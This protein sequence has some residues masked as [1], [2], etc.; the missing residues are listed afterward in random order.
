MTVGMSC[1]EVIEMVEEPISSATA[2]DITT[3]V[4]KKKI[5]RGWTKVFTVTFK[6]GKV[7]SVVSS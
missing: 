3:C 2:E 5:L 6:D 7:V 4:W 1:E